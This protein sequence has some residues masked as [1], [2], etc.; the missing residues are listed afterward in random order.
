MSDLIVGLYEDWLWL[1]E[2]IETITAEIEKIAAEQAACTRLMSVPGVGPIISTAL[3]AAIGDGEAFDRGRDFG[4]WLGLVPRQYSTGGRTVLG[5]ISKQGNT[6]LRMLFIQAAKVII[7]RPQNWEKF[8]FGTWLKEAAPRLHRN[9]LATALAN[10]LA[11]ISWSVL[12]NGR[13]F[14]THGEA[15]AI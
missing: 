1:D 7:M 11:R 6:Y 10:K 2:R 15:L 12:R 3:V 5:R 8:S 13:Y 4:A 9:K 14:D